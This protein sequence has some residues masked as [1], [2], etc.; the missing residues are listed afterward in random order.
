MGDREPIVS[1]EVFTQEQLR[2]LWER[3]LAVSNEECNVTVHSMETLQYAAQVVG[4]MKMNPEIEF[5]FLRIINGGDCMILVYLS[6]G[7]EQY[8]FCIKKD[9]EDQLQR[10]F[11]YINGDFHTV[12]DDE[13]V[14]EVFD[15]LLTYDEI[16]D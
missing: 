14:F 4:T 15:K 16:E 1:N 12:R 9:S 11:G 8:D 13:E 5:Y 2:S 10:S 3:Y 6:S 7:H